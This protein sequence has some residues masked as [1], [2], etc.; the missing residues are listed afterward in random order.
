MFGLVLV[1]GRVVDRIGRERAVLIGLAVLGGGVLA[2]LS[3]IE[4]YSVAPAMFAIGVGW[5]IGFVAATAMLADATEPT[6]RGR[7]LGF[8]DFL[9]LGA[10]SIGASLAGLVLGSL[11]LGALVAFGATLTFL[12]ATV[13]A[14]REPRGDLR[15]GV[16]RLTEPEPRC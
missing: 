2:L 8:A 4:V 12:L 6:E 3:R 1:V 14:V 15:R 13:L 11:G 10:A 5:N 7:L 9:A 16:I